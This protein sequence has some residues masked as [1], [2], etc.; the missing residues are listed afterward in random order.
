MAKFSY[1]TQPRLQ[2]L[3]EGDIRR[4]HEGALE[5]LGRAGVFFDN[6]EALA[7]LERV[8]CT[9]DTE[10]RIAKFPPAL[11]EDCLRMVPESFQLYDR[12]GAP[13][14]VVGG[15]G[16]CF[17][18]GS[19]GLLFLDRD[20]RTARPATSRDLIDVF[21]LVDALPL[22]PIQATA[23][24]V[25]DVPTGIVDCYRFYLYLKNSDKPVSGG[26]F[27][28]GGVGR[29]AAL[30]AV[31]AGGMDALRERP[32]ATLDVCSAPALKWSDVSCHSLMDCARLGIPIETISVPMPGV[33][34][35]ATMAGSLLVHVAESL[36]GIVLAQ[37]VCPGAKMIL[38]GA[39]MAF[40]M[41][42]S[43]TSLNAV[44]SS[45]IG[46]GYAQMARYYGIPCHTYAGLADSKTV[47]AQAGLETAMSGILAVLSGIHMISGPGM[48][49]FV[50]TMSLEKLV[51]DHEM[52][53]MAERIARGVAVN[54]ETLAVDLIC[55]LGPGGD[56]LTAKHTRRWF[57]EESCIPTDVID[58]KG[59]TDGSTYSP[60][61]ILE[62][63]GKEAERLLENHQP[64]ALQA[65]QEQQLDAVMHKIMK[66]QSIHSLPFVP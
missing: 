54:E 25:S 14:F 64:K 4:V 62:R 33:A 28:V 41:R 20:G 10:A 52:A 32:M 44:E 46:N 36:S 55:E 23:L 3:G 5:V 13:A 53:R 51:I 16:Q 37:A 8:G 43:T 27:T 61:D 2:F 21:R 15:E 6:E 59:R 34:S 57:R 49:D 39:P 65:G 7:V 50:N 30:L 40:D 26:A 63:A 31:A 9:V 38:G 42:Y 48:V 18:P 12:D 45:L 66:D 22:F 19:A 11:V 24:S 56:Y 17:D 60:E 29:I 47:D 58:K 35:P 1:D